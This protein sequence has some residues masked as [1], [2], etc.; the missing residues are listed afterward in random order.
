MRVLVL[1]AGG[2]LGSHLVE[3]LLAGGYEVVAYGRSMPGLIPAGLIDHPRLK[4]AQGLLDDSGA[5]A[6]A[7]EGCDSAVHLVSGSLPQS[8]NLDPIADVQI[9][10]VGTLRFLAVAR[11][12]GLRRLIFVSSGGTVYGT[13]QQVPMP[14]GHPTLPICSYGITKLGI[15]QHLALEHQLHGLG[16]QII[17]LANP[18]GERQRTQAAQGAI[19]VFLGKVLRGEPI[20]LWGD[21][22]NVRDFIHVS[23]AMA[24]VLTLLTYTGDDRVFNIGSGKGYSLNSVLDT[25]GRV[26]GIVPKVLMAPA[27]SCDV[28]SNVLCIERARAE[29]KWKPVISLEEGIG[30][31]ATSLVCEI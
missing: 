16:Y 18:Y 13:P 22:T 8:S 14:E 26:T 27:R 28:V 29:L 31:F 17:R 2:F 24:A 23:D 4:V 1:G 21:G 11:A 10:L 6:R 19:A 3:L 15:E 9:N 12:V 5:I 30:R 20:E 25:I 7:M